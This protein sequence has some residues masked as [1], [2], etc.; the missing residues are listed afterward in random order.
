MGARDM[1]PMSLAAMTYGVAFG[2]LATQSGFTFFQSF[3][4]SA[5]VFGG[6]A[7]L[8]ALDQLTAGAG[9]VA[10]VLAGAALNMRILLITATMRPALSHRPWWQVALG[11]H[12]ATD[13]SVALMQTAQNRGLLA[14]YWYLLGGGA[15]LLLTWIA[16][17][18]IGVLLSHGIPSAEAWGLDFAIVAAFVA[19]LP[20]LFRGR[21]DV[22]PWVCAAVAVIVFTA[23]FPSHGSWGLI[24]GAVIGAVMAGVLHDA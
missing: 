7:Q 18:S 12:V 20:G 8:V 13:A 6:S 23:F 3:T 1:I 17:T 15:S 22:I 11:V 10:A 14:D 5:L 2:L 9:A 4:M 24:F 19:M 16:A 21:A